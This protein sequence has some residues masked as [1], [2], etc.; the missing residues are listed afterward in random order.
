M[1]NTDH[2]T[3]LVDRLRRGD[4]DAMAELALRYGARLRQQALRYMKNVEDADEV[5][6]DVLLKVHRKINA[7]RGDS[8]LASWLHRVTFNTAMSRL[9]QTRLARR[10]ERDELIVDRS[11]DDAPH[12]ARRREPADWSQMAD[13]RILRGQMRRRLA[14]AVD[15]LPVIYRTPV[16]LRDF[17]GMST[18]EASRALRVKDQT[19]K[20]RLHRGRLMLRR[21]LADFANGLSMHH[22][23]EGT[24]PAFGGQSL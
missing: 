9:R 21:H 20:S 15:R 17:R 23:I 11:G 4:E 6:Q 1:H 13:E 2:E 19:M 5:V 16:V 8:A 18:E 7:F 12:A 10:F 14:A 22:P 3:L 24:L